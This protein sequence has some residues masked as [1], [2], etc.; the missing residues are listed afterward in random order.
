MQILKGLQQ[1]EERLRR[2][3]AQSAEM[4]QVVTAWISLCEKARTSKVVYSVVMTH[5]WLNNLPLEEYEDTRETYLF[6]KEPNAFNWNWHMHDFII[7]VRQVL[8]LCGVPSSEVA[9]F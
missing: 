1:I 6:V 7:G 5:A 2:V 9:G 4:L 3:V 8:W